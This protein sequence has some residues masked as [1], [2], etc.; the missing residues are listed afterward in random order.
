M[1]VRPLNEAPEPTMHALE[2]AQHALR[3]AAS[4]VEAAIAGLYALSGRTAREGKLTRQEIAKVRQDAI[5]AHLEAHGPTSATELG[6][7][8]GLPRHLVLHRLRLLRDTKRVR[9]IGQTLAARWALVAPGRPCLDPPEAR[10]RG[11][12]G[13][14]E[15]RWS[16]AAERAGTVPALTKG[17]GLSSSLR[18]SHPVRL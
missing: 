14:L 10:S 8:L 16:G 3:D 5:L 6:R 13:G 18:G 9:L 7:A 12:D 11:Q 2:R 1:L 17:L 15:L 4:A